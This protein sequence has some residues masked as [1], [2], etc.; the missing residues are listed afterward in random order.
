MRKKPSGAWIAATFSALVLSACGSGGGDENPNVPQPNNNGDQKVSRCVGSL[1]GG[2]T[3][4]SSG[5][6]AASC[7]TCSISDADKAI[8]GDRDSFA[9]ITFD[10]AGGTATLRA[11]AQPGIVFPAGNQA[12]ILALIPQTESNNFVISLNLVTYLEGQLQET[13][14]S[15]TTVIGNLGNSGS[16][17][18]FTFTTTKPFD[19]VE[20]IMTRDVS[21]QPI[22]MR[23]YEFCSRA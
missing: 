7:P 21:A 13:G 17:T 15:E 16:D 1:S 20:A 23:I 6:T 8:D 9:A 4:V 11:I 19:A 12:G 5:N 2:G 10:P 22:T 18:L 3:Q 14:S